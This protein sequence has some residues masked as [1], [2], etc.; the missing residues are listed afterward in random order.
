[1]KFIPP[2]CVLRWLAC[3]CPWAVMAADPA[4][5]T[6]VIPPELPGVRSFTAPGLQNAFMLGTNFLSGGTPEGDAAFAALQKLGVKTIVS[7]DGAPPDVET[8]RRHG[9]RYVHLPHGY[10]GINADLQVQLARAAALPG[11]VYVHCHHGCHR[12]PT[13]VAVMCMSKEGWPAERAGLWLKV[14]GTA[15]HYTG[16]YEVVENYRPPTAAELQAL[17]AQLPERARVSGLVDAMVALDETWE[18]LKAV[19]AAGYRTPA[20]QPDLVPASEA[21]IFREHNREARRLPEAAHHGTDFIGRFKAAEREGR[22]L[23][24]LLRQFAVTASP[25]LRQQLDRR[26]DAIA[27]TCSSCHKAYRDKAGRKLIGK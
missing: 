19:R 25:E 2:L 8:A 11:P 17:P 3:L 15:T 26:F 12:G 13:A 6:A 24:K 21:V 5:R 27:V 22:E 20:H 9:M 10:D 1:M 23:E 18:R 7:V 4:A 16:L 14:A